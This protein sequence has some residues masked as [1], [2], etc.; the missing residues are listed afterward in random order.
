MK[1]IE[2]RTGKKKTEHGVTIH[3]LEQ[4]IAGSK[5]L[6]VHGINVEQAFSII[7]MLF[8]ALE[9]SKDGGFTIL[10]DKKEETI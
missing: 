10:I 3:I 5:S 9:M 2:K 8:K 1:L 4:G 7:K 6:T